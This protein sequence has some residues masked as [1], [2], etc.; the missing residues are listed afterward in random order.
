MSF[1]VS[2]EWT[3]VSAGEGVSSAVEGM[4]EAGYG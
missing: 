1:S 2:D 4:G 3:E